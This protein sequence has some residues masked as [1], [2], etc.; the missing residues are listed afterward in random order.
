M[1]LVKITRYITK[2]Y[3]FNVY[4][5][6]D[7]IFVSLLN[8]FQERKTAWR[9]LENFLIILAVMEIGYFKLYTVT[10]CQYY[11]NKESKIVWLII[12]CSL[13]PCLIPVGELM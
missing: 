10:P 2:L 1:K 5:N 11:R 8:L 3:R 7:S 12:F 6:V 13:N 9:R 4:L